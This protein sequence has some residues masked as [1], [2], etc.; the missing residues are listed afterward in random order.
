MYS[1][2]LSRK[3]AASVAAKI[4]VDEGVDQPFDTIGANDE[5]LTPVENPEEESPRE[6]KPV[7]TYAEVNSLYNMENP[8]GEED[9]LLSEVRSQ[10]S[11]YL[12]NLK[13]I[14]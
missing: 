1:D 13:F 6:E 2:I 8:K 7:D 9:K 4:K 12:L 14:L 10:F 11:Q 5:T 3:T